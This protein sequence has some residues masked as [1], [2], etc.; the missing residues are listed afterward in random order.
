MEAA[1][2]NV[3]TIIEK[4]TEKYHDWPAKLPFALWGYRTSVRT[5][6]GATPYSLVYGMEAISIE[7]EIPSLRIALESQIP[8]VD[9]VQARY[10]ELL[11]IDEKRL[12]ALN[13]VQLYQRRI[14]RSFNKKVRARNLKDGD[15]VLKEIRAP[16]RDPRGKFKPNWAGP[17]IIKKILKG[18]AV[19][20][21]D[22]EGVEFSQL[23]NLD[24]LKKYHVR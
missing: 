18:G 13:Q 7:L 20:L 17:Y 5:P 23:T 19:Q 21:T 15:L 12:A 11:L 2:K 9:W 6:T 16:V 4:M 8:E 3:K 24:Q 14:S 10:E 22:I 1:N